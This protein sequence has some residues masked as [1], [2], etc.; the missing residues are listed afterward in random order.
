MDETKIEVSSIASLIIIM[1]LLCGCGSS[2]RHKLGMFHGK[3]IDV[4][5]GQP[6]EEAVVHVTYQVHTSG[7]MGHGGITYDMAVRETL[8]DPN[9]EYLIPEEIAIIDTPFTVDFEGR[10]QIFMP[11]Y[12]Y[13]DKSCSKKVQ[14]KVS[15]SD[16]PICLNKEGNYITW[17]LSKLKTKE[18]RRD[19]RTPYRASVPIEQQILLM[20]AINERRYYLGYDLFDLPEGFSPMRNPPTP[21][22]PTIIERLESPTQECTPRKVKQMGAGKGIS[23]G[24]AAQISY[25]YSPLC[26]EN[27]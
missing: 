2:N 25:G 9:G 4:E 7:W 24:G 15:W 1:L 6:I 16:K 21:P 8:T 26:D 3:V 22:T 18:E 11:G 17:K 5:T 10:L 12:G 20:Q 23:P 13:A 27:E 14:K 19:N